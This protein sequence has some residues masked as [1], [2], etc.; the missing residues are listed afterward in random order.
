MPE[1]AEKAKARASSGADADLKE[2][3]A[4]LRADLEKLIEDVGKL[5]R[6]R[7]HEGVDST[8]RLRD[9]VDEN[10]GEATD[11]ARDYVRAN[12]LGACAA[13]AAAGFALALLLKR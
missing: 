4:A 5:A 7:V 11:K 6:A 3:L 9:A 2:D 13:A 10:I 12:P 8:A 1:A